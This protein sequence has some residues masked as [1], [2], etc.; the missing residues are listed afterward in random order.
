METSLEAARTAGDSVLLDR[1]VA[2][3]VDNAVRHNAPGGCIQVAT[4]RP[5]PAGT[6]LPRYQPPTDLA[7]ISCRHPSRHIGS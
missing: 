3:L 1:L 7:S 5:E 4:G 2:N 6:A